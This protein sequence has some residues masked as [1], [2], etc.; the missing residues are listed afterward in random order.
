MGWLLQRRARR[1]PDTQRQPRGFARLGSREAAVAVRPNTWYVL[2][3]WAKVDFPGSSDEQVRI[4][5]KNFDGANDQFAAITTGSYSQNS[6]T[7]QTGPSTTSVTVYC[8]RMP[9]A[10][11]GGY[12]D[13]LIL[14]T[15]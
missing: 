15:Y 13:D 3:G 9:Y 11:Y 2:S 14:N 5:V 7:F 4:G 6:V 8:G 12:C 10:V 1:L